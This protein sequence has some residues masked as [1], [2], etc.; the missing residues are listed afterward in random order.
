VD[1]IIGYRHWFA[2]KLRMAARSRKGTLLYLFS[3]VVVLITPYWAGA[4]FTLVGEKIEEGI[5]NSCQIQHI[6]NTAIR[7]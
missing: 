7:F 1:S 4:Y 3:V 5:K 6:F 2:R